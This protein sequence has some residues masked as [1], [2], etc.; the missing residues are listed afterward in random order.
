MKAVLMSIRPEWCAKI[1][2]GHKTVEIRK[3]IPKLPVPF[4]VYIYCTEPNTVD[5]HKYLE[6][7]CG[8]RIYKCNGKVFAEFVC[9]WIRPEPEV[10]DGLVDICLGMKSC[11]DPIDILKYANGKMV[12]SWHISDLIIYDK[13]KELGEF[14]R[15]DKCPYGPLE[16]C[17]NHEYGCDGEYNVRRAPQSWCYVEYV[18]VV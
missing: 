14:K 15:C 2:S 9:D 6:T 13:P 3:T 1:A 5:P 10:A 17:W 8:E 18:E 11:V 12:Y 7:H 16:K 4:K